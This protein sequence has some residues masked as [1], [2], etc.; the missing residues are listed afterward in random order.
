MKKPD[1]RE[2]KYPRLRVSAIIIE[3][4]RILLVRHEKYGRSYWVLPGGGMDFGETLEEATVRELKEETNLDITV[5]KLV[6]VDD[7][8]PRDLHRHVVDVYFTGNVVGGDLEVGDDS[9]M[10]EVRFFPLDEFRDLQF[11]P[12][13][14]DRI[15]D[16]YRQGFPNSADY[17]GNVWE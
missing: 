11:E 16:A 1:A 14:V 7:I 3:D 15:V 2:V 8:L 5:D 6:F 4:E 12:D 17:L 13:I 9:H 10:H